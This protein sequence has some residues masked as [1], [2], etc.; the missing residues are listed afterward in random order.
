M[1]AKFKSNDPATIVAKH[2]IY[3]TSRDK[4]LLEEMVAE[5]DALRS[6]PRT[7]LQALA[8]E[9]R[10]A[11]VVDPRDVPGDVITMNSRAEILDLDTG[12]TVTFT[13]VFPSQANIDEEKISVLAPIGAGMLGYRVGDEFEWQV[14]D[15]VRRMRVTQIHYQPEAALKRAA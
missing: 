15:G 14:P 11:V 2:P 5:A 8:K 10:R 4:R 13:L 6:A 3:I 7:E 9:L 1:L 12:E